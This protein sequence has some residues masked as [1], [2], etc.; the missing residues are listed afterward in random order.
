M[1]MNFAK[2]PLKNEKFHA[3]LKRPVIREQKEER[4]SLMS[5]GVPVIFQFIAQVSTNQYDL[6][7]AN[8]AIWSCRQRDLLPE[9]M[10]TK[11]NF[12]P[13]GRLEYN[14]SSHWTGMSNI[15]GMVMSSCKRTGT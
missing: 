10:K 6:K 13:P 5:S 11:A 14:M 4:I 7:Y 3:T 8:P 9:H 2:L 12:M 1:A 15:P